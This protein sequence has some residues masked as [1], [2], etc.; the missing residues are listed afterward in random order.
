L[1]ADVWLLARLRWQISWN[2]FVRRTL[3][4]KI[5]YVIFWL[6]VCLGAGLFSALVGFLAGDLLRHYPQTGLESL[7]PGLLLT[8]MTLL[9]LLGSFSVAL[10]ALFFSS[11]LELLMSAPVNRRAV[12]VVKILDGMTTYYAIVLTASMPALVIYGLA[13]HYGALYYALA[14]VAVLGTPLLPAGLGA[15]LVMLVARLAPARRVREVLGL[16]TALFGSA[17]ALIGNTTRFWI[18]PLEN[19]SSSLSLESVLG[20]LRALAALPIPSFVAGKG[21]VLAGGGQLFPALGALAG[22]LLLTFGLFAGCVYLAERI[23]AS[24][25]LRIQGSGE[26]RR[27][28]LAPVGREPVGADRGVVGAVREP[29]LRDRGPVG[30]E[31]E[32]VGGGLVGAVREPPLRR[33][34]PFLALALKDWRTVPRDL[35]TF[36]RFLSPLFFLPVLYLQF[37]AMPG[38]RSG[39]SLLLEANK[40]GAPGSDFTNIFLAGGILSSTVLVFTSLAGTGISMEG[41]SWWLLKAAPLAGREILLGKFTAAA[42]PYAGFATLLMSAA[43]LVRGFSLPGFLY[44]LYGVLLLG[45]AMLLAAVGLAGPWA[46]LD[47]ENPNQMSAGW[48]V[49]FSFLVNAFILV[50]GC[51]ALCLPILARALLPFLETPAWVLGPLL[52]LGVAALG[53]GAAFAFGLRR[54]GRIGEK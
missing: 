42:V 39:T 7:L 50:A 19:G 52:A 27:R 53:G 5:G 9:L 21:L 28:G 20:P 26:A 54:L 33:A 25:W 3:A 4:K 14:L 34:A 48:G 8:G 12:F 49:L 45:C 10:N 46:R 30:A 44:G 18:A 22:F 16:V 36:A 38:G 40:L 1:I 29:P 51:L 31:R 47:W 6:A 2:R 35:R 37:F 15:L 24:G 23:Y 13:L 11:D 41:K 32:P 17:C 43:A